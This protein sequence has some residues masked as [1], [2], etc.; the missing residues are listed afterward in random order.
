ML[1][2]DDKY[3]CEDGCWWTVLQEDGDGSRYLCW[4]PDFETTGGVLLKAMV[5]IDGPD[6][7]PLLRLR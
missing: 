1:T 5:P 2:V 3:Q 7:Q 6:G 4:R